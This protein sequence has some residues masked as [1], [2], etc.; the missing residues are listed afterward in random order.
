[1]LSCLVLI[2]WPKHTISYFFEIPITWSWYGNLETA[3]LHHHHYY[4]SCLKCSL[5]I[6]RYVS[7][8]KAFNITTTLMKTVVGDCSFSSSVANSWT[9]LDVVALEMIS[10]KTSCFKKRSAGQFPSVMGLFCV[11]MAVTQSQCAISLPLNGAKLAIGFNWSLKAS[12]VSLSWTMKVWRQV[13]SHQVT[14][15]ITSKQQVSTT[16]CN[17]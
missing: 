5:I 17:Q 3:Y 9:T 12:A 4:E 8:P 10:L 11:K 7:P 15:E 2:Y 6:F 14:Y 1:M 13:S 16:T